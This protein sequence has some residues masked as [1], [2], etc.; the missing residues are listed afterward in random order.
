MDVEEQR[1]GAISLLDGWVREGRVP[2]AAAI[3]EAFAGDESVSQTFG[4]GPWPVSIE[5]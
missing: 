5:E 4:P 3:T 2:G 1:V